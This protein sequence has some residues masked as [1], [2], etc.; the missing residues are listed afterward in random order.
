[1]NIERTHLLAGVG[2]GFVPYLTSALCACVV[3]L[4]FKPSPKTKFQVINGVLGA[5]HVLY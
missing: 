1:M 2:L 3:T 4:M 5:L